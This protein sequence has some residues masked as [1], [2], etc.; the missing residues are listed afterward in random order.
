MKNS[1]GKRQPRNLIIICVAFIAFASLPLWSSAR[2]QTASIKVVNNSSRTVN[3][4]YLSQVN[5]DDWGPDQ[6]P[7]N[8]P[9]GPGQSFTITNVACDQS[10]IKVIG[11]DQDGCFLSGVVNCG[12]DV[13][14]TITNDTVA[15]CGGN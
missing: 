15:D 7:A 14:W 6:L 4:L 10:Q 8:S 1:D 2:P 12:G 5:L 9:I 11:E 3:N 13:T